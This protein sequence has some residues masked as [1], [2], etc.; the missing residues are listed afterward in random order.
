VDHLHEHF[1][2]PTDIR[3]G[4]YTA[5]TAP[6]AGMEMKAASIAEYT[7]KGQHVFF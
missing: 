7:W 6:G 5:P 4:S 3:G 1:V 2:T